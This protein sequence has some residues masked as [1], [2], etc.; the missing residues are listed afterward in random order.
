MGKDLEEGV[1]GHNLLPARLQ[2][3]AQQVQIHFALTSDGQGLHPGIG[4]MLDFGRGN[5]Q[6][7]QNALCVFQKNNPLRREGHR[8]GGA[9]KQPGVQLLLQPVDLAGNRGLG[10]IEILRRPGKTQVFRHLNE[11]F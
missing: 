9:V 4:V 8:S 1:K 5:F 6:L 3:F 7:L 10:D 2:N 11:T